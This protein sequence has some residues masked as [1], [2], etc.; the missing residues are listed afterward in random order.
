M[1]DIG[2]RAAVM[3]LRFREQIVG[4]G[5]I[6]AGGALPFK[7]RG[8]T[9]S[10]PVRVRLRVLIGDLHDGIEIAALDRGVRARGMAPIRVPIDAPLMRARIEHRCAERR[11]I[12]LG[13]LRARDIA[14]CCDKGGEILVRHLMSIDAEGRDCALATHVLLALK[15]DLAAP[16]GAG[17]DAHQRSHRIRR[18]AVQGRRGRLASARCEQGERQEEDRETHHEIIVAPCAPKV[19]RS[20]CPAAPLAPDAETSVRHCRAPAPRY[21]LR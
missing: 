10:A 19:A 2:A 16:N 11:A 17:V 7:L 18:A 21:R 4:R 3:S 1:P 6:A 5:R 13:P 9:P 14:C 8:Q 15:G 12:R 20:A